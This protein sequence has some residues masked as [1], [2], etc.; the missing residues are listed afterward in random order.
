[1]RCTS[2]GVGTTVIDDGELLQ[3]LPSYKKGCQSLQ[4]KTAICIGNFDGGHIGHQILTKY[5]L[6]NAQKLGLTSLALTF[7]PNPAL[8]FKKQSGN[9]SL[10]S[11]EQKRRFFAELG[12]STYLAQTFDREFSQLSAQEF[13]QEV[14]KDYLGAELI[15]VGEN[16]CFGRARTG[17]IKT[18]EDFAKGEGLALYAACGLK[19]DGHWVSSSRIRSGISDPERFAD[20]ITLLGRPYLLEGLILE[21][22][23]AGL[24]NPQLLPQDGVYAAS[25][26]WTSEAAI[27]FP[28]ASAKS[29]QIRIESGLI[30]SPS[31]RK[32]KK[33]APVAFYLSR[34]LR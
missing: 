26:A 10:F 27:L 29:E 8:F 23:V 30:H 2:I 28:P 17:D 19:N 21:E 31:L 22:G 9:F 3:I 13:C 11:P 1:M 16:F 20:A 7:E 14:L 18:L 6:E 5:C 34:F 25:I 12:F 32:G 4:I 24:K 15:V 33:G